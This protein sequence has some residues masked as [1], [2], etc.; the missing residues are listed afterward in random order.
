MIETTPSDALVVFED[1]SDSRWLTWLRPGFRHCYCLVRAE[2]GWILIDP[3]LRS[4]HVS[5]LD[6]PKEFDL[7]EHYVGLGR[8][9]ITGRCPSF[10]AAFAR[11]YPVTC[12]EIVKRTLGLGHVRAWTPYQLHRALVDLGWRLHKPS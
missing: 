12:V 1:R 11:L 6:L 7:V 2:R 5:W 4:L 10:Q 8:I 9:V 3:L